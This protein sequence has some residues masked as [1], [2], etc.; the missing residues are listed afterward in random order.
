MRRS[1]PLII[2]FVVVCAIA[3][4]DNVDKAVE[5]INKAKEFVDN[6]EKK[7]TETRKEVDQ[8]IGKILGENKKESDEKEDSGSKER[9]D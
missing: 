1:F 5:G 6:T 2:S 7:V 3:G 9:D 8:R 4:C